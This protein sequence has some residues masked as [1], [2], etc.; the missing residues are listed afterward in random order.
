MTSREG[1]ADERD[2]HGMG[3]DALA[4]DAEGSVGRAEMRGL[5]LGPLPHLGP[6]SVLRLEER[7]FSFSDHHVGIVHRFLALLHEA[8]RCL[9]QRLRAPPHFGWTLHAP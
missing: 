7:G 4:R 6:E 9:P 3:A 1:L 5:A 2:G 8:L